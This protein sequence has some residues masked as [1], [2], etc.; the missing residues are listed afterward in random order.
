[1]KDVYRAPR[2]IRAR[3]IARL[4]AVAL[5]VAACSSN[6]THAQAPSPSHSAASSRPAATSTPAP[7]AGNVGFDVSWPQCDEA[8]PADAAFGIVGLNKYIGDDFN[9][10]FGQ[11]M[12]W[13]K[14]L[15]GEN[16]VPGFSVYVHVG[17][18]ARQ[19]KHWP[20]SGETPFGACSGAVDQ[21]CSYEY[22]EALAEGDLRV[23]RGNN[24]GHVPIYEDVE[25]GYSWQPVAHAAD[26]V[27]T[28]AGMA[29]AF[30]HAGDRVGIYSNA[31]SW[32]AIAGSE[33]DPRLQHLQVWVLGAHNWAEAAANCRLA[34]FAGPVILAQ[35]AGDGFPIDE[36]RLCPA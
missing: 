29:A 10:C 35:E 18:P 1:M 7:R 20:T 30:E 21:A 24:V 25:L 26:N 27:A 14:K 22:G 5:S 32:E 34:S 15:P 28:M 9:P 16:G 12:K 33:T 2:R 36:D 11:E 6:S 23:L 17:N 31:A 3:T 13:A 19:A 4:A 8:L